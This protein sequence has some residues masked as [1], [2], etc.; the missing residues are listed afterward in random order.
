MNKYDAID[1]RILKMLQ[2]DA[3]QS[4]KK[5]AENLGMSKT[6]VYERIRKL[7]QDEVIKNY[8]AVLNNDKVEP[9]MVVFCSVSLEGQKI[10]ML[11]EFRK[12]I[13]ELLEVMECYLMGG[14]NDFLLKVIVKD[15]NE[16]HKFSSGKLAA[17]PHVSQIKSTFVLDQVKKSS[18][19]P[20]D[21]I[22]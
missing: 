14:A 8:V 9:N 6:P 13:D 22:I 11:N 18:V 4:T 20:V 16:Y 12:A 2:A 15:L 10:E 5:I 7:E 17:L 3:K 19:Y 1:I 21:K